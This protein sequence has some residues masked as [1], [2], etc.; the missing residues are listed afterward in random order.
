MLA[1]A[2]AVKNVQI[3][4]AGSAMRARSIEAAHEMIVAVASE[5]GPLR[6]KVQQSRFLIDLVPAYDD[7]DDVTG[8]ARRFF[9]DG[10]REITF[11]PGIELAEVEAFTAAVVAA[12]GVSAEADDLVTLLWGSELPHIRYQVIDDIEWDLADGS[13]SFEEDDSGEDFLDIEIQELLQTEAAPVP[14][15]P[16]EAPNVADPH[17]ALSGCEESPVLLLSPDEEA[18]L[19]RTLAAERHADLTRDTVWVVR[20]ILVGALESPEDLVAALVRTARTLVGVGD[21]AGAARILGCLLEEAEPRPP[22]VAAAVEKLGAVLGE[23]ESL[24][25]LEKGLDGGDHGAHETARL[26]V[27]VLPPACVDV[28]C[29][30]LGRL[31]NR[32]ARHV[33]CDALGARPRDD[34]PAVARWLT[35]GRWYLVRNIIGILQQM[36]DRRAGPLLRPVLSHPDLRVRREAYRA[37]AALGGKDAFTYLSRALDDPDLR[38][39]LAAAFALATLGESGAGP[40]FSAVRRRDFSRRTAEERRGFFEALGLTGAQAL[41]PYFERLLRSRSFFRRG[42]QEETACHAAAALGRLAG[43]DARAA[44]EAGSKSGP[45]PVRRA[46]RQALERLRGAGAGRWN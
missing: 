38:A 11:L 25:L 5:F 43:A 2:R 9:R 16:A 17:E 31:Q 33:V 10:V 15:A 40:L 27:P 46:C 34:V 21:L 44:L 30:M 4:P 24:A 19:A 37:Y 12:G 45:D 1:F 18:D 7:P 20:E 35:D 32:Q 8:L 6:L 29:E 3:Y 26:L 42:F 23:P 39:R 36:G 41:A 22:G 13:E 28:L 14:A